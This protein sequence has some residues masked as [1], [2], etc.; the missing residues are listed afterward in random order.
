MQKDN[1]QNKNAALFALEEPDIRFSVC[2][3]KRPPAAETT[4]KFCFYAHTDKEISLVCGEEDVPPDVRAREDGWR[5]FRI[6][7]ALEFSLTGVLSGIASVLAAEKIPVFAIST[8]D[9]D[10]ILVKEENRAAAKKALAAAGYEF[11]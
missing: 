9:T 5:A 6:A 7:G 4:E 3:L 1:A 11:R 10:Y 8:F 2:K